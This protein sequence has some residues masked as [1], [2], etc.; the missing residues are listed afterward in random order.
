M[1]RDADAAGARE[2]W[3]FAQAA[4]F[5]RRRHAGRPRKPLWE[6]LPGHT[7]TYPMGGFSQQMLAWGS[8]LRV[9]V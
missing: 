1:F 5:V 6:R 2:L 7:L 8:G 9:P 4:E 3:L